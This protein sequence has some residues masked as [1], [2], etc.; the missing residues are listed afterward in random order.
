MDDVKKEFSFLYQLVDYCYQK[1]L[2]KRIDLD[3][4]QLST[5]T[6]LFRNHVLKNKIAG[7]NLK[8]IDIIQNKKSLQD[9]KLHL[10]SF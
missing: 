8:R 6:L 2:A 1:D 9:G 3:Q 4:Y 10:A 5:L 7:R